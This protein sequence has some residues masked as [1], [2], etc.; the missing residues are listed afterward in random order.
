VKIL[1]S[2]SPP[3]RG[4]ER[5]MNT[6]ADPLGE[7]NQKEKEKQGENMEEIGRIVKLKEKLN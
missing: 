4:G 2:K 5:R 7:K 6:S 1:E 3:P